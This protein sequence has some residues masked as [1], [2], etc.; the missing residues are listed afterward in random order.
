MSDD[1][2]SAQ[3]AGYGEIVVKDCYRMDKW[4]NNFFDNII[5]IGASMGIFVQYAHMR[6]YN[7]KIFAVEP[8]KEAFNHLTRDNHYFRNVTY[9]N[10]A[11]GDGSSLLFY[12]T[13]WYTVN[14]FFKKDETDI[15]T[16]I[17]KTY[18]I[19]SRTL[20][21]IFELNN[22]NKED[23]NFIK[24]DCEGGERFLI[25]DDKSID[26]IKA[27]QGSSI[28][29]HFQT[30][31]DK[32]KNHERFKTFPKWEVYDKWIHDNF[33]KTHE[34]E[35]VFS[36]KHRGAGTYNLFKREQGLL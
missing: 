5:D 26:I 32:D 28:E 6:H 1:H 11:L 19:D 30:A 29:I 35:Y 8:C 9:I 22:I 36:S 23:K 16:D 14:L 4:D 17:S 27:S 10:E 24:I 13:G 3:R 15:I 20:F 21:Q 7:A 25:G 12:D 18:S 34:I 31:S 33:H 2:D